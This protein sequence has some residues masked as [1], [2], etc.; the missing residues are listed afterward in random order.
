MS[1][2]DPFRHHPELRGSIKPA[3]DS[4]F[5]DLDLGI[6]DARAAEVGYP[7]DWRTPCEEREAGRR[8]WFK[9]RWDK[10]LWVFAYGSLMWDPGL[11]F[12]E[13]RQAHCYGFQRSFCLWDEGARGSDEHPG[14]MLALDNGGECEGIAFRIEAAQLDH[15]TFVLFRREMIAPAYRPVWLSLDTPQGQIEAL[16]F[17]ANHGQENIKPGIALSEQARMIARAEGILGTNYDYLADTH[18]RLALLGIEDRYIS[19]LFASVIEH[20]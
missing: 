18:E 16:S 6:M 8:E 9:D 11:D 2:I 7:E 13:L 3:S 20:R 14:L 17:A 4:F 19:E 12:S 1:E 5:R 15:E 10:D